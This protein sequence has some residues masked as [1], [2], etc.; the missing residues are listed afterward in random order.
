MTSRYEIPYQ[1]ISVELPDEGQIFRGVPG[2]AENSAFVRYGSTL[3]QVPKTQFT[4]NFESLPQI[5]PGTEGLSYLTKGKGA[6]M[7][8]QIF[9]QAL[10][11]TPREEVFTQTI[12]PQNP[13]GTVVSS[14]LQGQISI[15]PSLAQQA[16]KFG[17]TPEQLQSYQTTQIPTGT[18]E[19]GK[20]TPGAVA[21]KPIPIISSANAQQLTQ[22]NLGKLQQAQSSFVPIG[23]KAY[24]ELMKKGYQEGDILSGGKQ[25]T[26]GESGGQMV[27]G[28]KGIS[29]SP[30]VQGMVSEVNKLAQAGAVDQTKLDELK[31]QE[32]MAM[33]ALASGQTASDTGNY[34][35]LD[36]W[37]NKYNEI[38]TKYESD[39]TSYLKESQTLRAKSLAL[40][41][42]T[43]REVEITKQLTDLRTEIDQYQLETQRKQI[44]ELSGQTIGF[45]LGRGKAIEFDRQFELQSKLLKEKNLLSELGLEQ[46]KREFESKSVDQQLKYIASDFDLQTQISDR[47]NKM[48]EG[49][50]DQA[51]KLTSE[52]KSTLM[53]FIKQLEGIN[54]NEL[55]PDTRLSLEQ[56]SQ[57]S[58]VPFSMVEEA[59]GVSYK[60]QVFDDSLKTD[61]QRQKDERIAIARAQEARL[62]REVGDKLQ[63][64][65]GF[66]DTKIESSVREDFVQLQNTW[67]N[68]L[69]PTDDEKESTL[70]TLRSLYSP[71]EVTDN[72]LKQLIGIPIE[73]P[74]TAD[75]VA[76]DWLQ[77]LIPLTQE[78]ISKAQKGLG[79]FTLTPEG[80]LK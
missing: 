54:P 30:A 15:S 52:A 6:V 27:I 79:G 67:K 45:A 65:M 60:R 50:L 78:Q 51:N 58:G 59:L 34:R 42:P 74:K 36:F 7:N 47:L 16:A 53:T 75:E 20:F 23:D 19:G 3:Y 80:K 68:K 18:F 69:S 2:N 57:Q 33:G 17:V 5:N 11:G 48:E 10:S 61:D 32:A 73:S 44:A 49:I 63:P 64:S 37:V 76:T 39:L 8:P 28:L 38:R 62:G 40:M 14:S 71:Q 77:D 1:N 13:Q 46:S 21:P 12:N 41:T 29:S 66:F 26:Y 25:L 4:G 22:T 31:R 72:A 24:E 43:Q 35:A 55:N 9:Q 70:R 56:L